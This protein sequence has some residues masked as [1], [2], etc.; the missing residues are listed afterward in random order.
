MKNALVLHLLEDLYVALGSGKGIM[1]YSIESAN[2]NIPIGVVRKI[3]HIKEGET[4]IY[5][6]PHCDGKVEDGKLTIRYEVLGDK[7]TSGEE[8]Y[9]DGYEFSIPI[10]IIKSSK[11]V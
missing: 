4:V 2:V 1:F 6:N 5:L 10:S 11:R 9:P 8:I 3:E 7:N